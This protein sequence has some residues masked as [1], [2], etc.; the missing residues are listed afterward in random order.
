MDFIVLLVALGLVVLVAFMAYQKL[1]RDERTFSQRYRPVDEHLL[2][3]AHFNEVIAFAG[4]AA[5]ETQRF[6]LE[7]GRY[8]LMYWFPAAVLVKVELFSAVGDEHE[9][10]ALKQGKGAA[11]FAV[12]AP[13]HYFCVIEPA[14]DDAEW[15]VEISRLGLL[16]RAGETG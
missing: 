14:Q 15:E 6:H 12:A 11:E 2:D 5:F 1:Q 9:V 4:D 10:I 8:K 3:D 16:S 13:G 7:A